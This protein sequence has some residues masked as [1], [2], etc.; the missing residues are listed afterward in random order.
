ALVAA[1]AVA[2][3]LLRA[4]VTGGGNVTVPAG[5]SIVA[6]SVATESGANCSADTNGNGTVVRLDNGTEG[7]FCTYRFS[8]IATG[9]NPNAR[10]AEWRFSTVTQDS[11]LPTHCGV[12]IPT[13]STPVVVDVRSF[14]PVGAPTGPFSAQPDA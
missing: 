6:S 11:I 7:G 5:I 2:L 13:G 1:V 8:L 4:P 10:L 12:S 3:A 14:V 9:S